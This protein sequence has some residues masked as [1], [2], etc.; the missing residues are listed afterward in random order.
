M[1]SPLLCCCLLAVTG[2]GEAP[3]HAD[4]HLEA[5]IVATTRAERE[6]V[7]FKWI[8]NRPGANVSSVEV[9]EEVGRRGLRT[10]APAR[11]GQLLVS[12]PRELLLDAATARASEPFGLTF[13]APVLARLPGAA[14]KLSDCNVVALFL[15]FERGVNRAHSAW[16]PWLDILPTDFRHL[17]GNWARETDDATMQARQTLLETVPSAW[18][19]YERSLAAERGERHALRTVA[20]HIFSAVASA[21]LG[22]NACARDAPV[23]VALNCSRGS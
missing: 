14:A 1:R 18:P 19:M 5:P 2:I 22:P 20:A 6:A 4:G 23:P 10:R 11:R 17:P 12:A 16:G 8:A 7:F 13:L 15:A 21:I 9:F 3:I